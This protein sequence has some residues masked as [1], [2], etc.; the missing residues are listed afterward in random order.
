MI[1]HARERL[2]DW[3]AARAAAGDMLLALD[4]D[5]TLAPIVPQPEDASMLAGAR[6]AIATLTARPDTRVAIV[7]GRGLADVRG[8]VGLVGL[9]Y[10][11]NHGL[12][13]EGP[14]LTRIHEEAERAR[15]A[16]AHC[17]QRLA[18]LEREHPGVF[19]EDKG[20]SLSVHYR[21]LAD[22]GAEERVVRRIH[23]LC[24]GV[25]GVRLH[26]GKKVVEVRPD[27]DWDKGRATVFLLDVL[28]RGVPG[29]PV[30]FIGDDR[31][32]E[33]AFRALGERGEGVI[34]ANPPPADTAARSY[35][36]SPAEVATLLDDLARA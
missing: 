15:P 23:A 30:V 34:V 10:A 29:A 4:F 22:P 17:S 31:T 11:G 18:V 9:Y 16:L 21:R 6:S 25:A 2:T 27:V 5:G 12:E 14:D 28:L 19:L 20:L 7:S 1:R 35:L 8:R 36:R 24:H 13:I 33:D 26:A 3:V 32:D